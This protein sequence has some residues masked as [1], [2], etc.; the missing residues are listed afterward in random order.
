MRLLPLL[1]FTRSAGFSYRGYPPAS[2]RLPSCRYAHPLNLPRDQT[3]RPLSRRA[4]LLRFSTAPGY[5]V[6]PASV[7]DL[8]TGPFF[9][10][11]CARLQGVA[12]RGL[13]PLRFSPAPPAL[14]FFSS[15]VAARSLS[16]G[17]LGLL[18][19]ASRALQ[20]PLPTP[21]IRPVPCRRR[22]RNGSGCPA[23]CRILLSKNSH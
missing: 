18:L 2:G 5:L 10:R 20:L 23:L 21:G 1:N 6:L 17:R 13:R 8:A 22:R 7:A 19:P 14:R 4:P 3:A 15:S 12:P 16:C 9:T 11:C